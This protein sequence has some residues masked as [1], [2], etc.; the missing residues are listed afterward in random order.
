MLKRVITALG[1]TALAC[2][3]VAAAAGATTSATTPLPKATNGKAVQ[4]LATGLHTPTSFA[5]GANAVFEGDGGVQGPQGLT[6]PG[7][8]FLIKG[9]KATLLAGSPAFVSGLAFHKGALYVAATDID[10]K[11]HAFTFQLQAWSDFDGTTFKT[12][13][14]IYT[15]PK[16]FSGLNGIAFGPDGRLYVGVDVSLTQTN[17]HG[18]ATKKTPYLYDVLSMNTKGKAL[19]VFASGMRQPWQIA[20]APGD[21]SP[22]V[23]DFG[24][25]KGAKNPPDFLLHIHNKDNYG[26]PQC[27]WTNAKLCKGFAKPFQ[28]FPRHTDLGGIGII[29]RRI[30]LSQFGMGSAPPAIVTVPL[31]GGAKKTLVKGFVAPVIGLGVHAGWV[32]FGDLTGTVYRVHS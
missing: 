12:H 25:D 27:N 3:G 7:G 23:T 17:D 24:Q 9:R 26:F 32:Y 29:G 19:T 8:V 20:F 2:G 11:T 14:V 31:K 13:K 30:F 28:L 5:F 4:V 18:P 22:F 16:G 1:A 10:A 21:K 6:A 15:A